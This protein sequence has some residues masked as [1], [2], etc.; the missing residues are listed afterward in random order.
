MFFTNADLVGGSGG[1]NEDVTFQNPPA[2]TYHVVVVNFSQEVQNYSV[3]ADLINPGVVAFNADAFSVNEPAGAATITVKRTIGATGAARVNYSVN[4]GM[5]VAGCDYTA[6]SG[7]LS[8]ADGDMTPKTF[9]VPIAN[10]VFDEN[11]EAINLTL[12]NASGASLGT[13][14]TAALTITDDDTG[15]SGGGDTLSFSTSGLNV[16]EAQ[17]AAMV[18]VSRS[19]GGTNAA[20]A[21]VEFSTSDGTALAGSDYLAASG[22]LSW[23]SGETATKT[24][25]V[26]LINDSAGESSETLNLSLG[27]ASGATLTAPIA[28]VLTIVDD[29][30]PPPS[31]GGGGS[32]SAASLLLLSLAVALRRRRNKN[33]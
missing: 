11:D 8:W 30:A 1:G 4:G 23:V 29:D 25:T 2:G 9:T 18:S 31:G 3:R 6:V 14:S 12:S 32:G 17:S 15:G 27:N 26:T 19:C 33:I 16:S 7:T 13:P 10:D 24:F 5:A 22:T 28:A 20:P 21:S